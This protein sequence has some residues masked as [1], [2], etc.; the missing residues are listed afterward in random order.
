[1]ATRTIEQMSRGTRA[2]A[3]RHSEGAVART[4]EEQ[5]AKLPSDVFLWAAGGSIIGSLTLK[6]IGKDDEALFI[7]QWVAPFLILGLYNKL[8]KVAGSDRVST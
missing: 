2:E 1:M 6:M 7:G 4:I 5:T 3:Q 8:V